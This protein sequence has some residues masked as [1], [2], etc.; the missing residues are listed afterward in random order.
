MVRTRSWRFTAEMRGGRCRHAPVSVSM[1]RASL[2]WSSMASCRRTTHTYSLPAP[3]CGK[4]RD[5]SQYN[6]QRT[7]SDRAATATAATAA[8]AAAAAPT[9][10]RGGGATPHLLGLDQARRAVDADDEAARDLGVQ[11]PGVARLFDTENAAD[12]RDD[13]VTGRVGG[14]VQVDDAVPDV[15]V[16]LARQRRGPGGDGDVVPGPA[17]QRRVVLQQQR[18]L[19]RVQRRRRGLRLQE[20]AIL[21]GRQVVC[22]GSDTAKERQTGGKERG[23]EGEGREKKRTYSGV[24]V[25]RLAAALFG[26]VCERGG[27]K[28][29]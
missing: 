6:N 20:Q 4:K 17:R 24:F 18:E 14:L 12:P 5:S 27:G 10:G 3:W 23:K 2:R 29:W 9:A 25:H 16:Q 21:R 1:A 19:G 8:A 11:G 13:L 28:E 15:V 7:V 22:G 26:G